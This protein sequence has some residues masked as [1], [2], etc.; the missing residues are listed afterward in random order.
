[1]SRTL[2]EVSQT[3]PAA[4]EFIEAINTR[5]PRRARVALAWKTLALYG[6]ALAVC[7]GFLCWAMKLFDAD[8][9]V[10][11]FYSYDDPLFIQVLFKGLS[12]N[13]WYLHNPSVG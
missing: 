7:L 3:V 8:L 13:G 5:T 11:L 12:E 10:P 2:C 1:M 6:T 4:D 9:R